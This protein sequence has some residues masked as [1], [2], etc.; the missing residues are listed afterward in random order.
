MLN[1]MSY[2]GVWNLT[3]DNQRWQDT[4]K[5][6]HESTMLRHNIYIKQENNQCL[7]MCLEWMFCNCLLVCFKL[8]LR[9]ELIKISRRGGLHIYLRVLGVCPKI[10]LHGYRKEYVGWMESLGL[11]FI[12]YP[13]GCDRDWHPEVTFQKFLL[14]LGI[15]P[16][17][18]FDLGVGFSRVGLLIWESKW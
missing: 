5:W 3:I 2:L 13:L 10:N 18:W 4:K 17:W 8:N 6:T 7:R 1:W 14:P 15:L 11:L 16:P 12:M 9:Y